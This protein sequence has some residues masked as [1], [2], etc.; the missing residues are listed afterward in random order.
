MLLISG[1]IFDEVRDIA[2]SNPATHDPND[3]FSWL[4]QNYATS[5]ALGIRRLM[6]HDGRSLSIRRFLEDV[7]GN[8]DVVTRD[9]YVAMYRPERRELAHR[10]FTALVGGTHK[11]LPPSVVKRDLRSMKRAE[12]RIRTFVNKRLA[13]LELKTR[14]RRLPKYGEL[15]Q[16]L[17]LM[18]SVLLKY[19]RLLSANAPMTLLPTW[20]YNWKQVFLVPWTTSPHFSH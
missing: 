15:S 1:H 8:V 18:E 20:Q 19:Q 3:F 7:L 16:T 10:R 4:A 12:L 17:Q 14:R 5:A 9:R 6:D 2:F 13:H 11:A